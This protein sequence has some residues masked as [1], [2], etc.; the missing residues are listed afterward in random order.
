MDEWKDIDLSS[1]ENVTLHGSQP[2]DDASKS[3]YFE[4]LFY[5]QGI[6]GLNTS[7][8]LEGA[9]V[10][11]PVHTIL[12]PEYHE[13]QEG[14]LHFHYLFQV[15]G[16]ILQVDIQN[17]AISGVDYDYLRIN[18]ILTNNYFNSAKFVINLNTNGLGS[19]FNSSADYNLLIASFK[20]GRA[21]V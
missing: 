3:D 11:R 7:A 13:N 4:S 2:V 20:I 8:F 17:F 9:V 10:G 1:Y 19:A 21:H 16:G 5:S 12:L 14:T 15:G 18:G 6:V